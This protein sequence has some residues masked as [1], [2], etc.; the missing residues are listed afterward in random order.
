MATF[1]LTGADGGTYRI[2]APDQNAALAAF[3]KMQ[4]VSEP[5][6]KTEGGFATRAARGEDAM[7]EVS[8]PEALVRGAFQGMS[9]NMAD[10]FNAA[11]RANP[12]QQPLP[13]PRDPANMS[14]NERMFR[15]MR[16]GGNQ[17]AIQTAQNLYN[18][19]T[20]DEA[21]KEAYDRALRDER[22]GFKNADTQRPILSL[23]HI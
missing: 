16:Q 6:R 5:S 10:E 1:E 4:G 7:P 2:D 19:A 21:T 23:I 9:F 12:N 3:K 18:L 15:S 20:G 17:G 22:A 13:A 11:A 8:M 14:E